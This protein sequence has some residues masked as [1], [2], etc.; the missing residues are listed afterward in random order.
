MK[1]S[2]KARVCERLGRSK[3]NCDGKLPGKSPLRGTLQNYV[4]IVR[5]RL[6]WLRV[7]F[8]GGLL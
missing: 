4:T 2:R 7:F 1:E 8:I 6:G 3:T 5:K